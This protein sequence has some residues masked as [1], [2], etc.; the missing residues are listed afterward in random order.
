MP[1]PLELNSNFNSQFSRAQVFLPQSV[2]GFLVLLK[3]MVEEF[4]HWCT[5]P[6]EVFFRYKFGSRGHSAF[7]TVQISLI[8]LYLLSLVSVDPLLVTFG[9]VSG[10]CRSTT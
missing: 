5:R 2:R 4:L 7:Q 1:E 3:I 10:G 8:A 6:V 9:L